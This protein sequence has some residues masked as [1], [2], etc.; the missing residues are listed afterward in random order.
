[1]SIKPIPQI[2][3]MLNF[4]QSGNHPGREKS[5]EIFQDILNSKKKAYNQTGLD[6]RKA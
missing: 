3:S 2:N 1:M 5:K 4:S 6:R